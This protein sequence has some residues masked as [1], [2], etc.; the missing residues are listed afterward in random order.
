MLEEYKMDELLRS[1]LEA[2]LIDDEE[3]LILVES[4]PKQNPIFP[5]WLY[6]KFS[7]DNW[8]DDEA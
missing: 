5:Y 1:E 4:E 2:G 7:L 8:T 6:E 3:F